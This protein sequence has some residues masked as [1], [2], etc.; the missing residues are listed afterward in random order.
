[1]YLEYILSKQDPVPDSEST[2]DDGLEAV[3]VQGYSK[4]ERD[5]GNNVEDVDGDNAKGSVEDFGSP[6]SED[7]SRERVDFSPVFEEIRTQG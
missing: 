7:Q 3:V 5:G 4:V 2:V 1:M 6:Q